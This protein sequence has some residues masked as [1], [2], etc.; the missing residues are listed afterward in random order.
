MSTVGRQLSSWHDMVHR[1][2]GERPPADVIRGSSLRCSWLVQP[3]S[4]L[5]EGADEGIISRYAKAYLLYLI[6]AVL[7]VDKTNNQVQLL[8]LTLLNNPWERIAEYSWG[9]AA[10]GYLYMRLYGVA[11]KNVMDIAEP[12]AILQVLIIIIYI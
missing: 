4:Q 11:K 1:I 6:G 3:F 2:L 9:S 10:L 5:P 7:F 8:Y 12:L